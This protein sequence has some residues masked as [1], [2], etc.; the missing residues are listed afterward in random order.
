MEYSFGNLLFSFLL[1]WV[2]GLIPPLLIR[3]ALL[4]RPLSKGV[5]IGLCVVFWVANVIVFVALGSKSK[6]HGALTL[7]AFVSYWIYTSGE[8]TIQ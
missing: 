1:T 3:Y 5:S 8:K 4:R 2:I 6:T 7:V